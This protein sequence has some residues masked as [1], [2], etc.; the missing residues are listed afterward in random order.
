MSKAK[1]MGYFGFVDKTESILRIV[2][3]YVELGMIPAL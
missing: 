2:E 3:E 1:K